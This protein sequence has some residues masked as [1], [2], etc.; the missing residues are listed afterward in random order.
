M[1]FLLFAV[2]VLLVGYTA[3][4]LVYA[5]VLPRIRM[6]AHLRGIRGYGFENRVAQ[7]ESSRRRLNDAITQFAAR[8]GGWAIAQLPSLH[9]LTRG[10]LAAAAI[11]DVSPET[12]HGFRVIAACSL[13]L[14]FAFLIASAGAFSPITMLL[15][16]ASCAAG[17]Q[18][19][20]MVIHRRGEKRMYEIDRS[21]PDLVDLLTATVEAGMGVGASVA[22]VAGRFKGALGDEL[23]LMI[24]QQSL[25][26]STAEAFEDLGERCDVASVRAFVRTIT[27][28][29]SMGV[30]IGPILRELAVD[31]RRR[32]RQAAREKMQKA[33][34]K[35][36]FPLMFLIFPALMLELMFP[37]AY[38][39]MHSLSGGG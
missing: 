39:L 3:R 24:K 38:S 22:M 30:S 16:I 1:T 32:R 7:S 27:R 5:L 37:A 8:A 31:T 29:E 10:E 13:P 28:G 35:L 6:S 4:L 20:A 14:L 26:M 9:P 19:P 18:L 23:R 25:G 12:V 34:V 33:P 21:L 15:V 36:L 17:W 11:T 2:G